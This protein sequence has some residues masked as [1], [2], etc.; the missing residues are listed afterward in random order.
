MEEYVVENLKSNVTTI[1]KYSNLVLSKYEFKYGRDSKEK[2][3]NNGIK[4][5][6]KAFTGINSK[7]ILLVGK[8][9]SGKTANLEFLTSLMFDS[10]YQLLILYGGYDSK[11]LEQTY[12]RFK[13]TFGYDEEENDLSPLIVSTMNNEILSLNNDL[14]GSLLKINRPIIIISMKRPAALR[15]VNTFLQNLSFKMHSFIIDDEGDQASLNTLIH[16][17]K[18]SA[19]YR[20]IV[21]MKK[22]L[23]YP[24]YFSVTA[25]PQANVLL[26]EY[27]E[28]KPDDVVLI[29][30]AQSYTG[31]STYHLNE[32]KIIIVS[33]NE[34]DLMFQGEF[35]DSLKKSIYHFILSACVM[36]KKGICKADMII[37]S[38]REVEKH[39]I[40]FRNVLH[41]ITS[42]KN[43]MNLPFEENSFIQE[44][45]N[46]YNEQFFDKEVLD[47]YPIDEI[48][49]EYRDVISN[50]HI[51]L[52][53]GIGE[54]TQQ[55]N[56]I[57]R[58]KIFIGGDLLQRGLTFDYLVTTFIT[59]WAKKGTMDTVIQRARWFGYRTKYIELCRIFTTKTIMF[60][61]SAL[62]YSEL[63]LWEQLNDIEN[64]VKTL[65]D[66]IIDGTSSSLLPTRPNVAFYK[67]AKFNTKW[68]NQRVGVF[69]PNI[70]KHNNTIINNFIANREWK[71]SSV[72]RRDG[73]VSCY[74][75]YVTI[76][77]FTNLVDRVYGT[78]EYHPFDKSDIKKAVKNQ[79][80]VVQLMFDPNDPTDIR[81]RTFDSYNKVSALQQGADTEDESKKKYEGD[82]FVLVDKE[83]ITVQVFKVLSKDKMNEPDKYTQYMFSFYVPLSYQ[84]Y[85]KDDPNNVRK[86]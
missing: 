16:K 71:K 7:N 55:F 47:L 78:F 31:S 80:I 3:L 63:D 23:D 53:N 15:K 85:K 79:K 35:V 49:E 65:D 43:T 84:G 26:G 52:Q 8:V 10:G 25:T 13:R 20:E 14:V 30:P 9:Q 64:G 17:L 66:I 1:G 77:D 27:S 28:L 40:M 48:L 37:H 44:M 38:D 36:I 62:A 76:E 32:S 50:I 18:A 75:D 45:S 70:I 12:K 82:S 83:A 51:I 58:Y 4:I 68:K 39:S 86:N 19:T 59:R 56:N 46:I 5:I 72:G 22:L 69:D 34:V 54:N 2:L 33:D 81:K 60:E 73:N 21:K 24:P 57:K 41:F 29:P 74:F 6:N 67:S 42:L 11:L 61:Y